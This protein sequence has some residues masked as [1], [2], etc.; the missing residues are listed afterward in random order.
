MI[1]VLAVPFAGMEIFNRKSAFLAMFRVARAKGLDYNEAFL[2]A[3]DFVYDTHYLMG[4]A[5]LPKA[6]RGGEAYHSVLR[7]AYTFRGYSHN[8]IVSM[9]QSMATMPD[10]KMHLD[11][12]GKSLAMLVIFGGLTGLPFLDDLLDELERLTGTPYRMKMRT[13]LEETGGDILERMGMQGIP[14]LLGVDISGSIKIGLPS[15]GDIGENVY[16]VYGGL[17]DKG[18][19]ALGAFSSGQVLRGVEALSPAFIENVLKAQRMSQGATNI[20]GK[21]LFDEQG[22]PIRLKPEEALAQAAGFRPARTAGLSS[23]K[24]TYQNVKEHYSA[25]RQRIYD[26]YRTSEDKKAVMED[27]KKYN[28]EVLKYGKAIPRITGDSLRG[29]L[30][31]KPD[32][33]REWVRAD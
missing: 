31:Q 13:L 3:R 22:Q 5:N 2:K 6:M 11:V 18:K 16:G 24:R 23:E 14:A 9:V 1:D 19:N 26:T 7:T 25:W 8:Y 20:H 28:N 4:K 10:G 27:V 12:L 30:K 29:S 15:F 21:Q 33:F 32:K 17:Y